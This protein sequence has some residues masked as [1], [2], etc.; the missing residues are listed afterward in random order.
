MREPA[1][2]HCRLMQIARAMK[3]R[4]PQTSAGLRKPG[5]VASVRIDVGAAR[6][7]DIA[8][9]AGRFG[10]PGRCAGEGAAAGFAAVAI[11]C[12]VSGTTGI[13]TAGA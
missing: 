5:S 6:G 10:G 7:T 1:A 12:A 2:W 11:A 3:L 4:P 9:A 13:A 8:A